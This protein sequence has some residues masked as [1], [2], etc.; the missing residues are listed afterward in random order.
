MDSM[1][2]GGGDGFIV[3]GS[4]G[5]GGRGASVERRI[6]YWHGMSWFIHRWGHHCMGLLTYVLV[7]RGWLGYIRTGL[8]MMDTVMDWL[9]CVFCWGWM[10]IPSL[11]SR[12][13]I[14][15]SSVMR[16]RRGT[17]VAMMGGGVVVAVLGVVDSGLYGGGMASLYHLVA[18]LQSQRRGQVRS[19]HTQEEEVHTD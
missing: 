13:T 18:D 17:V 19:Q 2:R 16:S 10:V 1:N 15:M 4:Q 5:R 6:N 7:D 9:T 14:S 3:H 12:V 11:D 8:R